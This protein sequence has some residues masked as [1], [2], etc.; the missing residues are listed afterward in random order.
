MKVFIIL[1]VFMGGL[2]F[3]HKEYEY[4]VTKFAK[5]HEMK[6]ISLLVN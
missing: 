6:A 4:F 3:K 2:F 5:P 1:K